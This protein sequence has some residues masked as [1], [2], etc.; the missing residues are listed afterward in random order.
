MNKSRNLLNRKLQLRAKLVENSRHLLFDVI[1]DFT[2]FSDVPGEG[3]L[4]HTTLFTFANWHS[5]F[6]NL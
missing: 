5:H 3:H 4:E 2:I 1:N 6:R